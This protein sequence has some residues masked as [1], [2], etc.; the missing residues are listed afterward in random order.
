MDWTKTHAEQFGRT[1]RG[2]RRREGISQEALAHRVGI[3]KNHMQLLEA[4][5]GTSGSDVVASNPR[6]TTLYGI[7]GALNVP[8][9]DLLPR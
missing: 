7:A 2:L 3:S 1:V 9:A 4:G 5:R 8:P 6:M